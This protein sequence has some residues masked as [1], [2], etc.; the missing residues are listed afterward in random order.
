MTAIVDIHAREILDSRGNPTVEVDVL[1][2]SGAFGRAAVPS[3]A[4]TGI[5]EAV[6]LRDGDKSRYSGKGVLKA[7]ENV[8][9]VIADA[10]IGMEA[11]NQNEIDEA[12]IALDGTENKGKL[13]ANAIL[14]VSLAVAKAAAE[15]AGLPLYRYIG[16]TFAHVLPVPMMNILNGGKHADNPIDIQEF[17][18]APIGAKTM[19]EAVRMGAEVFHA[20]KK[21]LKSAGFN[22]NVGDE[23]GFAPELKTAEEA[24]SYIV[25]AIESAGYKPGEDVRIAIDAAS[26][27][28][29]ENGKYEMKGEGK[30]FTSAEIV[31]YYA[32]LVEKFPIFSIEDGMA[33][34]DWEGWK[35][36]TDKLGSK[37]QLV[38]DDLFVTNPKRLAMGIEKGVANSILVKVNQIGTLTES[39]AAIE[40]AHKNGYTAVVSHRSGETEDSTIADIVVATNAGQIKT[41][42]LSRSDRIAKYNQLI[43]I[44]EELGD[45]ATY[46][47]KSILKK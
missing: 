16:G 32:N 17:M 12:M 18:I 30:S 41:G 20:L 13:G 40:L 14:G 15:E 28:F 29:Y 45:V 46:A 44:E 36:L 42:S 11:E 23:G 19:A 1:L 5:H 21:E 33:E 27:E 4:S 39:L 7:V 2:E 35:M 10:I 9:T 26:S 31:E 47:G 38:G 6:E 37:I 34:D 24:L 25:K 43:R 8:N 3:G 22:T